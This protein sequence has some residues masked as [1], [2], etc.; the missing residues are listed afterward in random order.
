MHREVATRVRPFVDA[1]FGLIT[2]ER[3][4]MG[5]PAPALDGLGCVGD[6][7]PL[8]GVLAPALEAPGKVL[9]PFFSNP[10]RVASFASGSFAALEDVVLANEGALATV[11]GSF[12][13][14]FA[15]LEGM[16]RDVLL[17]PS[18]SKPEGISSLEADTE[19]VFLCDGSSAF[20]AVLALGFDEPPMVC[21]HILQ[22]VLGL[23]S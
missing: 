7:T 23:R 2:D 17:N 18:L 9:D 13:G 10:E 8:T 16:T 12:A 14:A 19:D 15:V 6:F 20:S 21:D 22:S 1:G 11:A 4:F 3:A 5:V